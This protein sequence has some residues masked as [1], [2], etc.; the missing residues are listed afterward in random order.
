MVHVQRVP[1]A[2]T[3][4]RVPGPRG[5][6]PSRAAALHEPGTGA[7]TG[8]TPARAQ[9]GTRQAGRGGCLVCTVGYNF[10]LKQNANHCCFFL[11]FLNFNFK[12]CKFLLTKLH[13]Q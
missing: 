5:V 1:G 8:S 2:A 10:S 12:H 3:G 6:R 13:L 9:G 4:K 7:G 11:F